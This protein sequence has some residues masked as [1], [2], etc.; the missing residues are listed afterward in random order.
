MSSITF[1][2]MHQDKT[3]QWTYCLQH[4]Y[5]LSMCLLSSTNICFDNVVINYQNTY[6]RQR[7]MLTDF[8][9]GALVYNFFGKPLLSS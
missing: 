9:N 6:N 4:R 5:I 8:F 2:D 1:Y 7:E 3:C